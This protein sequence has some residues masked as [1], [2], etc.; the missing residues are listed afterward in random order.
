MKINFYPSEKTVFATID[1]F[2]NYLFFSILS[3]LLK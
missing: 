3:E 1:M 2:Y